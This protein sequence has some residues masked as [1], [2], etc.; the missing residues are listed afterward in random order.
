[1]NHK[2]VHFDFMVILQYDKMVHFDSMVIL[3]YDK[4]VH[5]DSMVILLYNNNTV[6]N[7][8]CLYFQKFSKTDYMSLLIPFKFYT[9]F[10]PSSLHLKH[11]SPS[12]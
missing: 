3:L 4:M 12:T 1:M 6:E 5:F 7:A 9:Y 8:K 11:E 10:P 2:M